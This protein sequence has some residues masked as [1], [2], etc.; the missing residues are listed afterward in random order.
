MDASE[1]MAEGLMFMCVVY[2]VNDV[3]RSCIIGGM[4]YHRVSARQPVMTE[5]RCIGCMNGVDKSG[6]SGGG[7]DLGI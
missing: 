2:Q 1:V 6:D 4:E 7:Y 5:F 3:V